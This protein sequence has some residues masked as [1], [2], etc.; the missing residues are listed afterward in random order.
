MSLSVK[1]A[2]L[3]SEKTQAQVAKKMGICVQ[4][5]RKLEESPKKMTI[6]QAK[7]FCVAVDRG[8]DELIF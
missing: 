3:M 5:Y 6:E 4:T 2:R 7:L 1:Q 8:L